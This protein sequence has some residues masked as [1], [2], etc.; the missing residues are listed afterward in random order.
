MQTIGRQ[1]RM[2]FITRKKS[3]LRIHPYEQ[4]QKGNPLEKSFSF[5]RKKKLTKEK[6]ETPEEHN[7]VLITSTYYRHWEHGC[8]SR[9]TFFEH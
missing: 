1:K 4:M 5:H 7:A 3:L 9:G 8:V 6:W 2:L